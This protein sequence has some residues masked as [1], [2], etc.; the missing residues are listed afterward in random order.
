VKSEVLPTFPW[1]SFP[2]PIKAFEDR[3]RR[4]SIGRSLD[5]PIIRALS[6]PIPVTFTARNVSVVGVVQCRMDSRLHGNDSSRRGYWFGADLEVQQRRHPRKI[7]KNRNP[8]FGHASNARN[9][10]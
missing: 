1:V 2:P 3:L 7:R 10:I 5:E 8:N 9:V 4:E 6:A